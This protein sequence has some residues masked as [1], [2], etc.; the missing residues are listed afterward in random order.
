M[1]TSPR[2]QIIVAQILQTELSH[3]IHRGICD[4]AL[5][6]PDWEL[7]LVPLR[8]FEESFTR[9]KY[10]GV[11][12]ALREYEKLMKIDCPM[13][14]TLAS[15][16]VPE[17][18]PQVDE[19]HIKSGELAADYLQSLGHENFACI[20]PASP[21]HSIRAK[22]FLRRL[23][24]NG[25]DADMLEIQRLK[26]AGEEKRVAQWLHDLPKPVA[27]FAT[28]DVSARS[29]LTLCLNTQLSVPNEVAILGCENNQGICRGVRPALSSIQMPFQRIGYEAARALD[30]L[31]RG[32][33]LKTPQLLFPP[34]RVVARASTDTLAV[35][36]P[37][38]R[39]AIQYIRSHVDE[40]IDVRA[41]AA[42]AGVSL[43]ILQ[44]RFKRV[45]DRTP[46]EE[47]HRAKI[48]RVKELL[49]S[50]DLTLAEIAEK[51]SFS[52]EYYMGV[53][54]KRYAHLTPG[55]YRKQHRLR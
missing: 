1:K 3:T 38:L 34:E 37:H 10:D 12:I 18:I 23:Q 27:L 36:D 50:T 47:V 6:H 52:A 15:P 35:P 13:V 11:I 42:A 9:W 48:E 55:Q 8:Q 40:Q 39:R 29:I 53:L 41:V 7:Q 4:Y 16:T 5:L 32:K 17:T 51:T 24:E 2:K 45:L 44:L 25:K 14:S 22:G 28:E 19:D 26:F 49:I 33:K 21:T 46:V 54:F 20:Y 43:R 30:Q 31:L